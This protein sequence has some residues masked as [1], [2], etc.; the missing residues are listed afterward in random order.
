LDSAAKGHSL[1]RHPVKAVKAEVR[2][3]TGIRPTKFTIRGENR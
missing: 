3:I 2:Q 1:V